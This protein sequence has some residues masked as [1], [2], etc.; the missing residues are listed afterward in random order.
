MDMI[1]DVPECGGKQIAVR[2]ATWLRGPQLLVDG[3]PQKGTRGIFHVP[4]SAGNDVTIRLASNWIDPI[5]RVTVNGRPLV[6]ARSLEWYEYLWI[7]LPVLMVFTGGLLGALIGV[8]AVRESATV[9][10]TNN[11]KAVKF[12]VTG[13][14]TFVAVAIYAALAIAI[15]LVMAPATR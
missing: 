12:L 5:P 6:L 8:A 14:V 10:R 9:F 3:H 13:L 11:S 1:L 4:D 2:P 7:G 15:R